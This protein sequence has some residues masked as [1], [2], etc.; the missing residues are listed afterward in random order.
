MIPSKVFYQ[1]QFIPGCLLTP[2]LPREINALNVQMVQ[3]GK[4]EP[5][6]RQMKNLKEEILFCKYISYT[7]A[8]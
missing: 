4:K 3:K 8:E 6:S 7:V 2:T 5:K 1:V